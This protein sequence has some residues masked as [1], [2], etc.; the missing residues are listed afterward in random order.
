MKKEVR[1]KSTNNLSSQ[2]VHNQDGSA[3]LPPIDE[4]SR[5]DNNRS[6]LSHNLSLPNINDSSSSAGSRSVDIK[7]KGLKKKLKPP[8]PIHNGASPEKRDFSK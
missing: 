6:G 3:Y 1:G 5:T 7:R 8:L 4:V 2:N